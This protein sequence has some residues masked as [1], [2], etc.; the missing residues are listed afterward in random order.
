MA[1]AYFR[2]CNRGYITEIVRNNF[3]IFI[4][5]KL[6]RRVVDQNIYLYQKTL[7]ICAYS[8]IAPRINER[9][10]KKRKKITIAPYH[11]R[12]LLFFS[13]SIS[14]LHFGRT[15]HPPTSNNY[16]FSNL[17]IRS[18]RIWRNRGGSPCSIRTVSG[19][20]V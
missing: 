6:K 13:L 10:K 4:F 12:T 18:F 3:F 15:A 16:P 17:E 5:R 8:R 19:S 20:V 7:K 9:I 1:I 14:S 2:A 11:T